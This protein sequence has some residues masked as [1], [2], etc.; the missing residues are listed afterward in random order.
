MGKFLMNRGE[1]DPSSLTDDSSWAQ[2]Q[3]VSSGLDSAGKVINWSK[4]GS[5]ALRAKT[6]TADSNFLVWKLKSQN[7]R[8]PLRHFP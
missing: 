8:T 3:S 4:A 5:T 1:I 2:F 6:E 7:P